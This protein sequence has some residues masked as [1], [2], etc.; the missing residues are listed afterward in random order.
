[1]SDAKLTAKQKK[2]KLP[3]ANQLPIGRPT[4]YSQEMADII[5]ERI[6]DGESLRQICSEETMPNKATVFRWLGKFKEFSD[7]Y[8]RARENQAETLADE[9]TNIADETMVIVKEKDGFTEVVLDSTA[10]AR[11]RLRIDTRKWV[12]SKLL[13]KKYGDKVDLNHG[14]QVDNPLSVLISQVS[15][16]SLTPQED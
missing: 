1:M 2:A 3:K 7:Q 14:G 12:A 16:S 8:A 6:A 5:C 9:I 13:P 4:D 15:G 11:N 10:V